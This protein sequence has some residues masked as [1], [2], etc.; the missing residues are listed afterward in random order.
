MVKDKKTQVKQYILLI[1]ILFFSFELQLFAQEVTRF[2]PTVSQNGQLLLN[3]FAG[4]HT[5]PQ[6]SE[7]DL[8][9]DGVMDLVVFD[10]TGDIVNPYIF[11]NDEYTFSPSFAKAFPNPRQW[12]LLRDYNADGIMDLFMAPTVNGIAGVEVHT[13]MNVDGELHFELASI[14][15]DGFNVIYIPLG[16]IETQVYNSLADIPAI[17]DVDGDGDLD[18]VSFEV[19]GSTVTL[20]NNFSIERTGEPGLDYEISDECFGRIVESGFSEQISLSADGNGCGD[21]LQTSRAEL[22]HSGSTVALHDMNAD[23]LLEAVIGD[24]SN[25]GLVL[26]TN[27]G[28]EDRAWF[29]EQ[30]LDFPSNSTPVKI[31]IFNAAFFIDI[32]HDNEKDMIVAPNELTGLQSTNHIWHY[33]A[34]PSTE[35]P[36]FEIENQNFLVDDMLYFGKESAPAF[37]DF[38]L[39]GLMDIIVGSGGKTDFDTQ[40]NPKLVLI[41]NV[42]TIT[43]PAFEVFDEDYLNFS[44]F[45]TTSNNFFP[46]AGDLDNDGD[47]DLLIGDDRG[48]LYFV[49][50]VAGDAAVASFNDPIYPYQDLNPGQFLKPS[51]YD[52]DDDGL[53]D[54]VIGERNFNKEGDV[55]GSLNY[56][57]NIGT[58]GE[59][60]FSQESASYNPIFGN[61]FTKDQGFIRNLSAPAAIES[62]GRTLILVGTESGKIRLYDNIDANL[63][64]T[65]DEVST[66]FGGIKEGS[67]TYPALFDLD[68]DGFYEIL[69]GNRRGGLGFYSTGIASDIR[70]STYDITE[71][72]QF[73]VFPNPT[74][75]YLDIQSGLH[76]ADQFELI[77][78]NGQLV[79][80]TSSIESF[81]TNEFQTGTYFLKIYVDTKIEVHKVMIVQ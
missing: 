59:P 8:N 57:R 17:E 61:V 13:G 34:Q 12:M 72:K 22:R 30:D 26:L 43:K 75:R 51:I 56:F 46:T 71:E 80:R 6:F 78:S 69:V 25:D 21:F 81:R 14:T 19:A 1:F 55:Q 7:V 74:S 20:Y 27:A 38:N 58:V 3:P 28:S 60:V 29:S 37:F 79:F 53:N 32:N 4:G 48:F 16:N 62:E 54:I 40:R 67:H 39:D 41:K 73:T 76:Q 42:G 11:E 70:S 36:S 45:N 23:G 44:I 9:F 50:N 35:G 15:D 31:N 2:N 66:Q 10:R 77:N 5:A 65:F 18:I 24:I 33:K 64:G 47:T 52:F 63:N 68:N 49:E